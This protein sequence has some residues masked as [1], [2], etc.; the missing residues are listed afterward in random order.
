MIERTISKTKKDRGNLAEERVNRVLRDALEKNHL[1]SWFLGQQEV[2][3]DEDT[4]RKID[5]WILTDVGKIGLQVKSSKSGARN[6]RQNN[7]QT[8]VIIARPEE[9]DEQ[10]MQKIISVVGQQRGVYLKKRGQKDTSW[11]R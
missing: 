11:E 2:T 3:A 7:P 8:P 6:F 5:R 1:P 9:T 10:I 4:R